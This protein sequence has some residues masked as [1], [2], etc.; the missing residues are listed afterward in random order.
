M[1]PKPH[2][3]CIGW[4][5]SLGSATTWLT[6]PTRV[7]PHHQ[8]DVARWGLPHDLSNVASWNLI[9]QLAIPVQIFPDVA[10]LAAVPQNTAAY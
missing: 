1:G 6:W 4:H 10:W 7:L 9:K 3:K 5:F 8:N 2:D